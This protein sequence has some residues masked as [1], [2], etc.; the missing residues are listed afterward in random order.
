MNLVK[1]KINCIKSLKLIKELSIF[2]KISIKE[3]IFK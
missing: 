1:D 3:I 2:F